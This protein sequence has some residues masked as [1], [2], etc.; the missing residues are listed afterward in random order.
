MNR[1][2]VGLMAGIG[3]LMAAAAVP[4][5]PRSVVVATSVAA[6]AATPDHLRK[7]R[8]EGPEIA[9]APV[10]TWPLAGELLK[11]E[12]LCGR[13]SG[14]GILFSRTWVI[15]SPSNFIFF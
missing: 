15:F 2:K 3:L 9:G 5:M 7:E 14:G 8:R 4:G 10:P 1:K 6:P 12:L 13:F 11:V